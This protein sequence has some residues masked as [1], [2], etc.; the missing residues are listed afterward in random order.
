ME[1]RRP[2]RLEPIPPI[3]L[4]LLA[5][6]IVGFA[7]VVGSASRPGDAGPLAPP[8]SPEAGAAIFRAGLVLAALF[9]AGVLALV[10]W[11]LW[12]G[13]TRMRAPQA[14]GE[15]WLYVVVSYL[16]AAA[17]IVLV[18]LRVHFARGPGGGGAGILSGIFF[19]PSGVDLPSTPNNSAAGDEWL[20]VAIVGGVLLLVAGF[21]L[22]ALLRRREGRGTPLQ[23]LA[24]QLQDAVEDGL[25]ELEAEP[26]PRRAVIG[27]YARMERSLA[28]VGLPRRSSETA[29]EYLERLL[30]LVRLDNP[31]AARLTDLFQVAKFS[32][33]EVD[34]AMKRRAIEALAAVRDDLRELAT[35]RPAAAA[36][37]A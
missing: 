3:Q 36:V 16:Q 28:R 15:R 26:D 1:E 5:L 10:A 35:D 31:A 19:R 9:E 7:V 24:R 25:D 23:Q 30:E 33:H 12:P 22:R 37:P 18:W 27:A 20:T 2:G 11:A 34:E 32:N 21:G 8:S 14:R 4:G 17:I 29:L 6:A 13:R